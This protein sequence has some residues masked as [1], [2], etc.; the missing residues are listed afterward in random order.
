M[1]E[2]ID[3]KAELDPLTREAIAWVVRLTSGEATAMDATA[4]RKWRD[5]SSEHEAAFRRAAK[6]WRD[7]EAVA[8]KQAQSKN[9]VRWRPQTYP[10][11]ARR[12]FI[13]GMAAAITGYMVI[14][15][16]LDLWPSLGE[17]AAD[18][19]TGKGEQQQ[20]AIG[21]DVSL[22]LSTLTSI[23][24]RST[25]DQAKIELINGEAAILVKRAAAPLVLVADGGVTTASDANFNARCIDGVVSVTCLAGSIEVS[26][27]DQSVVLDAGMQV[28]YSAAGLG[29]PQ[30]VDVAQATSWRS[31]MLIFENKPLA[32]VIE[33]INRYRPGRIVV[34]NNE[35]ARRIVNGTFRRDQI[36]TFVAQVQNLFGAKATALPAGLLLLS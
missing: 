24:V 1:T 31:G 26:R 15:P 21:A 25:P 23:A 20:V 33:E 5:T 13:G 8:A 12:A 32:E 17:L 3:E 29:K 34:T 27:N 11:L 36:D 16:P 28:S 14:R 9:V 10:V 7:F 35:L 6:L 2:P 30:S 4:L 19:R 18:Y 22:E